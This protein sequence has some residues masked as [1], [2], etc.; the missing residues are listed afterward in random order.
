MSGPTLPD[1]AP[2]AAADERE[3]EIVAA[4]GHRLAGS[5]RRPAGPARGAIVLAPAMGVPRRFYAPFARH[6]AGAGLASLAIDYR[7]IGGSRHGP[8]RGAPVQLHDWGELDLAAAVEHLAAEL[9]GTPLGWVGHS[10]GGQLLGLTPAAR[11]SAALLV[12]AQSGY[13]RYW[14]GPPRLGMLALWY[15]LPLL[16]PLFGKLPMRAARQGEDVPPGVALEWA[17][18]GRHPDYVLSYARTRGPTGFETWSGALRALAIADDRYAPLAGVE[19]LVSYF[20]AARSEVVIVR[21]G[22]AGLPRIQHFGFFRP[23]IGAVLWPAASEW[24]LAQLDQRS[25]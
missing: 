7:G 14:S 20:R 24:L 15:R 19:A 4:D 21:P 17:R 16:V 1:R 2:G 10:V 23:S 3:I 6:L 22:D 13:H 8:L 25:T 18:W 9:P 12:A 11:V 5:L